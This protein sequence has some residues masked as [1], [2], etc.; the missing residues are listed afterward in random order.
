WETKGRSTRWAIYAALADVYLWTGQYDEAIKACDAVINSGRVGLIEG[1][2][3]NEN[4]WFT[5]FNPGN[6]NEGIFE[7]QF[8]FSKNQ[9]NKLMEWFGSSYAWQISPYMVSLFEQSSEDIRGAGATYTNGDY[10]IWKYNGA[11]GSTGIPRANNDQN[12]II[13]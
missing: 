8:D 12:W 7:V 13:Y 1:K 10:K 4:R 5:M 6:S 9:T 11:E 3:N 2:V